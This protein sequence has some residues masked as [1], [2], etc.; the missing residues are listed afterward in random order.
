MKWRKPTD[1]VRDWHYVD[2]NGQKIGSVKPGN[3]VFQWTASRGERVI[4]SGTTS[5]LIEAKRMVEA[6]HKR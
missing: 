1:H 2:G 6:A 4:A 3:I 5:S